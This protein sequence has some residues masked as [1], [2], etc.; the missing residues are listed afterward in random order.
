LYSDVVIIILCNSSFIFVL[1]GFVPLETGF[2]RDSL[3]LGLSRRC[4]ESGFRSRKF[5]SFHYR[6]ISLIHGLGKFFSK[7]LA[8][9]FAPVLPLLV[10]PNYSAFIKGLQIQDNFRCVLKTAKALAAKRNP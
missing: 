5:G 7:A 6:P 4:R 3:F 8:N 1:Y 10:S 9:H 2:A